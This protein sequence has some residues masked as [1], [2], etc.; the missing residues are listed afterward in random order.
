[1]SVAGLSGLGSEEKSF[2]PCIAAYL[3]LPKDFSIAQT[4]N[5][6]LRSVEMTPFFD[7]LLFFP[8]L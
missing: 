8:N 5:P 6:A 3:S 4:H 7:E 2:A 1:M